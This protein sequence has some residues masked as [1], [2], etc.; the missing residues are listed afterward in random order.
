MKGG[1][2]LKILKSEGE[3]DKGSRGQG[4][5]PPAVWENRYSAKK[6]KQKPPVIEVIQI[7][8]SGMATSF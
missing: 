3:G 2:M 6:Q 1:L 4:E 8:G 5:L 7:T